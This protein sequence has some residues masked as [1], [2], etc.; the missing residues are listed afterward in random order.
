MTE[1]EAVVQ[2]AGD[3]APASPAPSPA[4]EPSGPSEPS[5]A[6]LQLQVADLED[7]WRRALAEVDNTRKR[8]ARDLQQRLLDERARLAAAWLPVLDSLEMA[9]AHAEADPSSIISGV[10]AVRD[11]ALGILERLGYP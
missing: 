3:A 8:Y 1:N 6:Q 5:V 4:L 2:P 10:Q 7:R 11:Q 9:L